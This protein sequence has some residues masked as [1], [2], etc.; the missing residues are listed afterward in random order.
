MEYLYRHK[1]N[2]LI[3]LFVVF[4]TGI[5]TYYTRTI[6]KSKRKESELLRK[7]LI[8]NVSFTFVVTLLILIFIHYKNNNTKITVTKVND[9]LHSINS[10]GNRPSQVDMS[11]PIYPGPARF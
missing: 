5:F 8:K 3:L 7:D 4:A 9:S 1:T 10:N 2:I 6:K 11:E